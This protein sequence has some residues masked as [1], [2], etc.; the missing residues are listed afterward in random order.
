MYLVFFKEMTEL[1]SKLEQSVVSFRI[2]N[3]FPLR[4]RSSFADV[5]ICHYDDVAI[6]RSVQRL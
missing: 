4:K 2:S 6:H 3:S 1:L 5:K